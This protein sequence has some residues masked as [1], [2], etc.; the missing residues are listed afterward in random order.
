MTE[1]LIPRTISSRQSLSLLPGRPPIFSHSPSSRRPG[2]RF[3]TANTLQFCLCI[4]GTLLELSQFGMRNE[5]L[6]EQALKNDADVWLS[7]Q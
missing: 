3:R 1:R 7:I 2:Y 4:R 6:G 5:I